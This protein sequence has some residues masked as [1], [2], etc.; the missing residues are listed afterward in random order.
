MFFF[1]L[2]TFTWVWYLKRVCLR[3]WYHVNQH[4]ELLVVRS[5]AWHS[6]ACWQSRL[7]TEPPHPTSPLPFSLCF[8]E[9]LFSLPPAAMFLRCCS[10]H[11][12]RKLRDRRMSVAVK[13]QLPS[14]RC[15]AAHSTAES[16]VHNSVIKH[17][18]ISSYKCRHKK[19]QK[20][21][22]FSGVWWVRD[23]QSAHF[24]T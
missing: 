22:F 7:W 18:R 21:T 12:N 14:H 15:L 23:I 8:S 5:R 1:L 3:K 13:A 9:T 6:G 2:L 11:G 17:T 16:Q 19:S 10:L 4:Y 24:I 20:W